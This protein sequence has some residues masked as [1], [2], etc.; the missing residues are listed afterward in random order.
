[1]RVRRWAV[2]AFLVIWVGACSFLGD[3]QVTRADYQSSLDLQNKYKGLVF[4]LPETPEW[5][6]IGSSFVYRK[7]VEGGHEFMLVDAVAL[8]KQPAFDHAKLA[9]AFSAASGKEYKPLMLPFSHFRFVDK[10][11]AMEFVIEKVRWRC[12]LHAYTCAN[13]GV[14]HPGD[15]EY[16]DDDDSDANFSED[17]PN[18]INS[19][20]KT[21]AS[22][23]GKWQALI[24][25]YNV[26][27]RSADGKQQF[28]LSGDGSEGNYYDFDTIAWSPDSKRLVAYRIRPGFRRLVHYTDSFLRSR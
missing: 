13:H 21:K 24:E 16:D 25:N 8:T 23:D 19:G 27:V 1:M 15:E 5:Q 20:E 4:N 22:P 14:L 26:R 10:L 7:T 17:A 3:A 18:A 11:S 2:W 6:E 28:A 9:A 12:D